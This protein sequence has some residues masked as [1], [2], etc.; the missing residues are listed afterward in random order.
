MLHGAHP[1]KNRRVHA[2][3]AAR[4]HLSVPLRGSGTGS[5][6]GRLQSFR[7]QLIAEMPT[8]H[9]FGVAYP[10]VTAEP[11]TAEPT[12]EATSATVHQ[13]G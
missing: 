1:T 13:S 5:A 11:V 12:L 9:R 4:R 6:R 7:A 10:D 2:E 8:V 3:C